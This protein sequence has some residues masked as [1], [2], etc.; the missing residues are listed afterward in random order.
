MFTNRFSGPVV[1]GLSLLAGLMVFSVG[2]PTP[3]ETGDPGGQPSTQPEEP[4]QE[5]APPASEPPVSEPPVSEPPV[6]ETPIAEPLAVETPTVETLPE[7]PIAEEPVVEEPVEQPDKPANPLRDDGSTSGISQPVENDGWAAEDGGWADENDGRPIGRQPARQ[8]AHSVAVESPVGPAVGTAVE[9]VVEPTVES[10]VEPAESGH[11]EKNDHATD[12]HT[13]PEG[14]KFD[15]VKE[16][17]PIFVDWPKPKLAL[18]ITGRLEGYIEPCGCAG[19]DR[20]QGGMSRRHSLFNQLRQRGW[21][22]VGIDVG[23]L[24]KGFG[25]QAELKF[26]VV[27]ECMRKMGYDAIALGKTDLRLP[28]G[29]LVSVAASD[30]DH[31]SP[32]ISANVGLFGFDA[33][34]TAKTR[35]IQR[36]G[37]K[38]ALTAVLGKK[39]QK[40]INNDEIEMVDP[41]TA[42]AKIVPALKSKADYLILLAHATRD[43]S[44]ELA[45]KFPQFDLVISAGGPAEPPAEARKI[46]GSQTPLIEVGEKGMNAVVLG[47]FDDPDTPLRYQR[48]PLDS[49][50]PVS[51]DMRLLMESYQQQLESIG[52]AGLGIRAVPHP[53]LQSNGHYVGSKKCESCHEDSYDV[54]KKSG[55]A[56]ALPTLVNLDPPRNHDPEC[57]SCH[58]MGWHPTSHFPYE[59]GYQS[60]GKTPKLT[61]VG[62]ESCHGP[63]SGHVDAEAGADLSL[64]Q[65]M[66]E[67]MSVSKA[68]ATDVHSAKRCTACHDGD[69]SPDFNF[70]KYWPKI[71][72]REDE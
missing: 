2:C 26:Q 25:R 21:P 61:N 30:A 29:E 5:P 60:A 22:V 63:G 69:N 66:Q 54:W 15:P 46:E 31:Q 17:G 53:Q 51:E 38:L 62:C 42:L 18:I 1:L 55:H 20:M 43:E 48:V 64:Q 45:K 47:I 28:T 36:G 34:L 50:F 49:R 37:V 6:A 4:S 35:I 27:V 24:A 8:L 72:H 70:E 14:P 11:D 13:A 44:I 39:F 3:S 19:M 16:N 58:V 59:G 56:R 7:K 12:D 52:F 32:F 65:K 68:E 67:A 10:A 41:A 9:P 57:I 71:E 33:G 23:G 40:E